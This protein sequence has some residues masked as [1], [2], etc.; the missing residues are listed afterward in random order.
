M[1]KDKNPNV[2]KALEY[3]LEKDDLGR[4]LQCLE[5]DSIQPA[6]RSNAE[7]EDIRENYCRMKEY[8]LRGIKDPKRDEVYH[9]LCDRLIAVLH[10]ILA[11]GWENALKY[12]GIAN[13]F[14]LS[15]ELSHELL[16]ETLEKFV[17]DQAMLSLEPSTVASKKADEL[18]RSH[19][20]NEE[21]FFFAIL[22]S[23]MWTENDVEAYA[24]LLLSPTV[25]ITDS[26]LLTTA[27]SFNATLFYDPF[28]IMTL[29]R[30]Y[31]LAQD[32][33]LRQRAFVGWVSAFPHRKIR[34]NK[35]LA[36]ELRKLMAE[37]RVQEELL[38]LQEQ[39]IFCIDTK[40]DQQTVENEIMP[41][42]LKNSNLKVTRFGFEEKEDDAMEDIM[43]PDAA[44]KRTEQL[45]ESM[46]R[47]MDLQSAGVDIYFGGFSHMKR[48]P[49]FN[50]LINWFTPF[51]AEH[52]DL[53]HALGRKVNYDFMQSVLENG[54]FCDSDKYSFALGLFSIID[55]LPDK[56]KEML[57]NREAFGATVSDE[58]K[59]N[60]TYVRRMYLQDLYR[61]FTLNSAASVFSS[62]FNIV[63]KDSKPMLMVVKD[64]FAL[65]FDRVLR[66]ASFLMHRGH[67]QQVELLFSSYSHAFGDHAN[68]LWLR[69]RNLMSLDRYREAAVLLKRIPEEQRSMKMWRTMANVLFHQKDYQGAILA[70]SKIEE[71][72]GTTAK[73][74]QSI[75]VCKVEA[76]QVAEGITILQKLTFEKPDDANFQRTLAWAYLMNSEP[77]KADAIYDNLYYSKTNSNDDW[78]NSG[79]AKWAQG[80]INEA[81]I[82]FQQYVQQVCGGNAETLRR[83]FETDSRLLE[84]N[85]ISSLD[86]K[87]V[88]DMVESAGK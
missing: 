36:A 1:D 15:N 72:S 77:E 69:A 3:V 70:F 27:I 80:K 38:E 48:F 37:D 39:I 68:F 55:Q 78:L 75:A 85:H 65:S 71:A 46:R 62:P 51:Y 4:A 73:L 52:P 23:P 54:P 24:S 61:F 45:E 18:Y 74:R 60:F 42:L 41:G 8:M 22:C 19:C 79:Y 12:G 58:E 17:Q 6:T 26:L 88:A 76:G 29:I 87:I 49:F 11:N 21:R 57:G 59:S 5:S 64:Y 53:L 7:I 50:R 25:D 86:V 35:Q 44:E 67:H 9:R 16:R 63:D 31:N 20:A 47:M 81:V 10:D 56:I 14:S 82:L 33:R 30:V 40:K 32:E 13:D 83:D 34:L 2:P 28:K 66:L 84:A 43:N